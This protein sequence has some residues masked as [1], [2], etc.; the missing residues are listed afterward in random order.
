ML[1]YFKEP[2]HNYLQ[3]KIFIQQGTTA[4]PTFILLM[5]L[6]KAF[7]KIEAAWILQVLKAI[8]Y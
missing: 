7:E 6:M 3:A 8:D 5:D 1:S 4:R 2:Q